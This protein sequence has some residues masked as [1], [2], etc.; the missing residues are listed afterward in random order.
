M[1]VGWMRELREEQ[2]C[3]RGGQLGPIFRTLPRRGPAT[4]PPFFLVAPG[5]H[6]LRFLPLYAGQASVPFWHDVA[7]QASAK[8]N[9]CITLTF[10]RPPACEARDMRPENLHLPRSVSEALPAIRRPPSHPCVSA[11][12]TCIPVGSAPFHPS[13]LL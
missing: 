5:L 4:Y 13:T 1:T 3:M 7:I 2:L 11:S 9:G 12:E 6:L 10:S 8:S